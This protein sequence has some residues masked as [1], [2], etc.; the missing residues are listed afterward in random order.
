MPPTGPGDVKGEEKKNIDNQ[1][2]RGQKVKSDGANFRGNKGPRTK[3]GGRGTMVGWEKNGEHRKKHL[4]GGG[5][6]VS[7]KGAQTEGG[8]GGSGG[9]ERCQNNPAPSKK[10][11]Q[12]NAEK[13]EP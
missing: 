9:V 8:E 6:T 2:G 3:A 10:G 1:G 11:S 13:L 7:K 4:G 12:K 5:E